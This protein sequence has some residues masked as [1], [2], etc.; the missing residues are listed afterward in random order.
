MQQAGEEE[1][2]S[3][4]RIPGRQPAFPHA[5]PLTDNQV[6]GRGQLFPEMLVPEEAPEAAERV[7]LGDGTEVRSVVARVL[8]MQRYEQQGE[9]VGEGVDDDGGAE[10][11]EGD[12]DKSVADSGGGEVGAA[13][14]GE[15]V[16]CVCGVA[17]AVL[18]GG[19]GRSGG[20]EGVDE[21]EGGGDGGEFA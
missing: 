9:E 19:G 21:E 11:V 7:R 14:P 2:E 3:E 20:F 15:D 5:Q 12:D 10:P 13:G 8:D 18:V 16:H 4:M 1:H 6:S 17:D